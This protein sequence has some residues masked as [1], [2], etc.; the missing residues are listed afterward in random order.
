MSGSLSP[1]INT[2]AG[3]LL[4]EVKLWTSFLFSTSIK[5]VI[6]EAGL[7]KLLVEKALCLDTGNAVHIDVAGAQKRQVA[8]SH[9]QLKAR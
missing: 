5:R 2:G 1:W 7:S 9:I 6:Q 4:S 3:T 8:V